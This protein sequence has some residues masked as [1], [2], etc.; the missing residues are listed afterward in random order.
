MHKEIETNTLEFDF[1]SLIRPKT[2]LKDQQ[3]HKTWIASE[4][5]Y[6]PVYNTII[7]VIRLYDNYIQLLNKFENRKM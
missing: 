7:K 1:L 4:N 6:Y 3:Q 5:K 2:R